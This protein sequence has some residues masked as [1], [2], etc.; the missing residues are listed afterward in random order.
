MNIGSDAPA[1]SDIDLTE[2]Q[3]FML[4]NFSYRRRKH[5]GGGGSTSGPYV[6]PTPVEW[7]N[8]ETGGTTWINPET[9][10]PW[11]NPDQ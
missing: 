10:L 7:T 9:G 2:W 4:T 6:P 8:P 5:G 3:W 11:L 1:T